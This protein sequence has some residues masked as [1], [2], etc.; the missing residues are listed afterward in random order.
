MKSA[1][2]FFAQLFLL[3]AVYQVSTYIVSLIEFPL[4]AS[5]LGMILLYLLLRIGIVKLQYVEVAA[6]FLLKHLS[7]FFVPF[8]VGLMNYG[9]LI[10]A[11]GIQLILMIIGSTIIGLLIT[12]G[13]TQ[14]L[15]SKKIAKEK[16]THEHSHSH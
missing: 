8:A 3:W 7:L 15:S 6:S 4:P 1:L 14:F 5:V 16:N 13:S 9:G 12:G 2:L 11:S 10:K